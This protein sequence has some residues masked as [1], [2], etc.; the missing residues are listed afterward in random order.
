MTRRHQTT[1]GPSRRVGESAFMKMASARP[2]RRDGVDA[3]PGR[4]DAASTIAREPPRVRDGLVPR[5]SPGQLE[6][7]LPENGRRQVEPVLTQCEFPSI[8]QLELWDDGVV[9][10]PHR[11][12]AVE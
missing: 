10:R 8:S 2:R 11:L 1:S 4:R 7:G 3:M 12:D 6:N 9:T 5:R